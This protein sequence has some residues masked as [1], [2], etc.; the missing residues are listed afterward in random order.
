MNV[1]MCVL[2]CMDYANMKQDKLILSVTQIQARTFVQTRLKKD[3]IQM[4]QYN[5]QI[6]DK[7]IFFK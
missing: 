6:L 7:I 4:R 3:T 5:I 1:C 2:V